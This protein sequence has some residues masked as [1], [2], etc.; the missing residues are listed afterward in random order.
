MLLRLF[1]NI[2]LQK[3]ILLLQEFVLLQFRDHHKNGALGE[4]MHGTTHSF[5]SP[6]TFPKSS[7]ITRFG[8]TPIPIVERDS[9]KQ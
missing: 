2:Y 8:S 3:L 9:C 4:N 5:R 6:V 1:Q 7:A